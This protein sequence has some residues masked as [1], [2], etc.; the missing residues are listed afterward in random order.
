MTMAFLKQEKRDGSLQHREMMS[1]RVLLKGDSQMYLMARPDVESYLGAVEYFREQSFS[2]SWAA[3]QGAT[4]GFELLLTAL[5][6]KGSH[7][8]FQGARGA[9]LKLRTSHSCL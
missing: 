4:T 2:A 5:W 7:I 1:A 9:L 8:P 3:I 6:K